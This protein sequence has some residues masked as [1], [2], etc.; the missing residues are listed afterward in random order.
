MCNNDNKKKIIIIKA[1]GA[2]CCLKVR[3]L[4]VQIPSFAL[5]CSSTFP[6][7]KDGPVGTAEDFHWMRVTEA[8]GAT[9]T[10]DVGVI[11]GFFPAASPQHLDPGA[12]HPAAFPL[13]P[14]WAWLMD[15]EDC[16]FRSWHSRPTTLASVVR[17]PITL[18][19]IFSRSSVS[20]EILACRRLM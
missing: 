20:A 10:T 7:S 15:G 11:S 12:V 1:R 6:Q 2:P 8:V 14:L 13:S 19:S 17:P 3:G 4:W 18:A 16:V 5:V 9:V